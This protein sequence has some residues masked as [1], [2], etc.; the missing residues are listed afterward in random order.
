MGLF[1]H[2]RTADFGK[3]GREAKQQGGAVRGP[4]E[5]PKRTSRGVRAG[6]GVSE[7][8][9]SVPTFCVGRKGGGP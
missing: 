4:G 8:V 3:S 9:L 5:G 6:K 2:R 7:G 1:H